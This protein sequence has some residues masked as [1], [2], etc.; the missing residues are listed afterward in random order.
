AVRAC[1]RLAWGDDRIRFRAGDDR[2]GCEGRAAGAVWCV[3]AYGAG[4]TE[5]TG[6]GEYFL[7]VQEQLAQV[8]RARGAV[9]AAAQANPVVDLPVTQRFPRG[10]GVGFAVVGVTHTQF[11][12]EHLDE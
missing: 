11:E 7:L 5:G 12:F 1:L 9:E 4:V 8:R 6:T 10:L 3:G 2:V